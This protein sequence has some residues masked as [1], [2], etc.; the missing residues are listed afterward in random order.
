MTRAAIYD[1]IDAFQRGDHA[2][3]AERY[4][5]DIEWRLHAPLSPLAGS[6]RGK[7]EVLAGLLDVYR[8]FKIANYTVPLV[9]VDGDRAATISDFH[10]IERST[11]RDIVS[12][13]AGFH[14]FR[15]GK[16]IEYRGFSDTAPMAELILAERDIH[17]PAFVPAAAPWLTKPGRD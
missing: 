6:R 13:L 5:D 3:L 15:D 8:D 1:L 2:R 17:S 10:V 12:H 16:L 7:N 11:G 4:D 14:R 9:M